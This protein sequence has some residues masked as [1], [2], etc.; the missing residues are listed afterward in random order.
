MDV[1]QNILVFITF[2]V[3]VGYVI[4]KFIWKPAFLKVKKGTDKACGS[5]N[6]GC[7]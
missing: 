2:L 6:C 1:L 4:T 5:T 3:A 7:N